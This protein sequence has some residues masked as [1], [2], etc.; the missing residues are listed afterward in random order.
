M[1]QRIVNFYLKGKKNIFGKTFG[2]ILTFDFEKMEE[3]HKYIQYLFPLYEKSSWNILAPTLD[4]ET[5]KF[6]S[7]NEIFKENAKKAFL[8][9]LSFY[10]FEYYFSE[11][12][13]SYKCILTKKDRLSTWLTPNN[14]N[15]KRITRILI[16]LNIFGMQEESNAF[17]RALYNLSLKN[18]NITKNVLSYWKNAMN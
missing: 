13:N 16:F 14:H 9:M 18:E 6:L 11:E 10:G 5:V 4:D 1:N 2:D 7:E 15:F 3:N 8:K 12:S 17:Y